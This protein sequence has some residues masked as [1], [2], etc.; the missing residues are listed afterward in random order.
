[1]ATPSEPPVISFLSD[2][3]LDGAAAI[4]RGVILSICP[5]AQII[6][7]SHTVRKFAID[8]GAFIL[9]MALPYMPVG[10]HLAVVDPGVGTNRRPIAVRVA[11]GDVLIGPD[12][13]LLVGAGQELGGIT[14]AR[15]LT[16]RDLWLTQTSSTFHG[17]DVFAPVT[18]HLAAATAEF[19]DV[20]RALD[21]DSLVTLERPAATIGAGWLETTA[22][23]VDSFG[24]V[25]LA[26][27]LRD[28][29]TMLGEPIS[30]QSVH[31]EAGDA[32]GRTRLTEELVAA[33]TFG[34]VPSG[35]A[36]VYQDSSGNLAM[37]DNQG[38]L[39][40]RL[41]VAVGDRIR[42]SVDGPERGIPDR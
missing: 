42:L 11:R 12:N 39:A 32:S 27:S 9:G 28:L 30:G 4:C 10:S 6:D 13:G 8:Q 25:R 21:V 38:N 23:Y 1:V 15:E 29:E 16:N 22:I 24:N 36:L 35:A 37:A 2:F 34:E 41:G 7:I 5:T 17:R 33:A 18:A 3:G 14:E 26:G 40:D 20:G 19:D 31:L